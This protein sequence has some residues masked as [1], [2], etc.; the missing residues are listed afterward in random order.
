MIQ[1][2]SGS[3]CSVLLAPGAGGWKVQALG[4]QNPGRPHSAVTRGNGNDGTELCTERAR[5]VAWPL[6]VWLTPWASPAQALVTS[7]QDVAPP[8]C[9]GF[10]LH[11]DRRHPGKPADPGPAPSPG[12]RRECLDHLS[13]LFS[14]VYLS[15][16]MCL[17]LC[18]DLLFI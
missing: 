11:R 14:H 3:G 10:Q 17:P 1:R 4:P 13:S 9:S 7:W 5:W 6:P 16:P 8:W 12:P 18:L 2:R 15:Q